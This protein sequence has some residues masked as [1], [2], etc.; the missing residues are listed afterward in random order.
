MWISLQKAPEVAVD[1]AMTCAAKNMVDTETMDDL[2]YYL[3][4]DPQRNLQAHCSP[5]K[6]RTKRQVAHAPPD[7][8]RFQ[9]P[10]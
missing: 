3:F 2:S 1:S 9:M 7:L 5:S 10:Q 6:G 8:R 4:T